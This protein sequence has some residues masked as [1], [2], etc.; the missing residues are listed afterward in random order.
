M[1]PHSNRTCFWPPVAPVLQLRPV[2]VC[3]ETNSTSLAVYFFFPPLG[4]QMP[5]PNHDMGRGWRNTLALRKVG[6]WRVLDQPAPKKHQW[7]H[8]LRSGFTGKVSAGTPRGSPRSYKLL[9]RFQALPALPSSEQD[10]ALPLQNLQNPLTLTT[11]T[12]FSSNR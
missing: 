8:Q 10:R 12:D 2:L 3:R 5:A 9:T 1:G 6:T 4:L 11:Q 7:P